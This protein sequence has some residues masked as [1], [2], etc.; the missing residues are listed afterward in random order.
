MN[1]ALDEA[2]QLLRAAIRDKTAF[3]LLIGTG[4]AP[5]ETVG[6]LAQQACEKLIKA[7]WFCTGRGSSGR[8]TW[9][10]S[11]IWPPRKALSFL[12]RAMFCVGLTPMLSRSA[13]KAQKSFG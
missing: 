13:T 8:M 4:G 11:S 7:H 2:R 6:F 12:C 10:G 3:D 1:A 9:N 5:H